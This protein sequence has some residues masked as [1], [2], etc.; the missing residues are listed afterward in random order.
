MKSTILIIGQLPDPHITSVASILDNNGCN[1]IIFDRL[2]PEKYKFNQYLN[3]GGCKSIVSIKGVNHNLA[4]VDAI[5]WRVKP[6]SEADLTGKS[7]SL[8]AS[9]AQREWRSVLESL[10]FFT[11]RAFWVNPRLSDLR[12]RNKPIQLLMAKKLGFTIPST[13][14]S[15]DASSVSSFLEQEGD[16]HIYKVL[17]WYFEPPDRLVFTCA[18]NVDH[19]NCNER[20]ISIA[21]GIFQIQIPKSYEVRVTVVGENVFSARIDSQA[22]KDTALDWRRNQGILHYT[23]HDLPEDINH[24]LIKMNHKLG[25]LY[26][27]YDLIVTPSGEY[28]FLEVNHVGQWLWL[29]NSTGLPIS[30]ALA[31]LLSE[32]SV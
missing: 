6:T 2:T 7:V 26:G 18:I 23:K 11:P 21:P 4:D 27:A 24:M 29:E 30:N 32:K 12:A 13:L 10:E 5:W 17:T 15:N 1:V 9:F 20:S 3:S 31:D 25:L 14:I 22:H 28:I 8:A 16:E 19:V